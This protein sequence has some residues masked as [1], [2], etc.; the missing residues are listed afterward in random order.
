VWLHSVTCRRVGGVESEAPYCLQLDRN[1][2][3]QSMHV[4][5]YL[6]FTDADRSGRAV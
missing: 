1:A 6:K 5:N 2:N 3:G 4:G